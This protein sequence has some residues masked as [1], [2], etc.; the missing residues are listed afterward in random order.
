MSTGKYMVLLDV[1]RA[2]LMNIWEL[3]LVRLS[4]TVRN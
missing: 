1:G 3:Q 2:L 4:N